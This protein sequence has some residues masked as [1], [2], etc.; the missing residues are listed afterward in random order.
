MRVIIK[1]WRVLEDL[2][3]TYK[4]AQARTTAKRKE[5][6]IRIAYRRK[7]DSFC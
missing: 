3:E 1:S 4:K 5:A 2:R 7:V 6:D